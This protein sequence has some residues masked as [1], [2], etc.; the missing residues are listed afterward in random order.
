MAACR[1]K[2]GVSSKAF[3]ILDRQTVKDGKTCQ[4][5]THDDYRDD[6]DNKD[7]VV[8]RCDLSSAVV[9]LDALERGGLYE[10]EDDEAHDDDDDYR[11]NMA[12]SLRNEAAIAGGVWSR[13]AS[14]E[15]QRDDRTVPRIKLD[16]Y[17]P[18]SDWDCSSGRTAIDDPR[19]YVPVFRTA[20]ISPEASMGAT[21]TVPPHF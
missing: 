21:E 14:S 4:V 6:D 16:E 19:P 12:R 20:N 13:Q 10:N 15:C 17:P 2:E 18:A 8:F 9:A 1:S 5:A 7:R 3:L 11:H